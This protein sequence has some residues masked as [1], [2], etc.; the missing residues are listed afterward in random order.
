MH[1]RRRYAIGGAGNRMRPREVTLAAT[2][3]FAQTILWILALLFV[4]MYLQAVRFATRSEPPLDGW[5]AFTVRWIWHGIKW[6]LAEAFGVCV[7]GMLVLE[8]ANWA[9]RLLELVVLARAVL[10]LPRAAVLLELGTGTWSMLPIPVASV[11][12][13]FLPVLVLTLPAPLLIWLLER[14]VSREW[15]SAA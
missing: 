3:L 1:W 6:R 13:T 10:P 5:F 2:L 9:R 14:K 15:F 4:L 8:R 12:Q 11:A 7:L